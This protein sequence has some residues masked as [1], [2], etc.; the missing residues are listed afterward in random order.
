M[1]TI[2]HA[3]KLIGDSALT[4]DEVQDIMDRLYQLAATGLDHYVAYRK[5]GKEESDVAPFFIK[6]GNV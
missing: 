3:R 6:R 2:N 1:L 5:N 4:D